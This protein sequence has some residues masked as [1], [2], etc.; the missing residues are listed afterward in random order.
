MP[1]NYVLKGIRVDKRYFDEENI[2]CFESRC[3]LYVIKLSM[4][5]RLR[6]QILALPEDSWQDLDDCF[7]VAEMEYLPT[8]WKFPRRVVIIRARIWRS[9]FRNNF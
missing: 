3:L 2:E 6:R 7:S 8:G 1:H 9:R 4:R 5:E